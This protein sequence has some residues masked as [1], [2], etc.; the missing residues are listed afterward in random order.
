MKKEKTTI[1]P[2]A[3]GRYYYKSISGN[4]FMNLKSPLNDENYIEITKA[5]FDELTYVAPYE[6]TAEEI[7]AQEVA[8]EIAELK[9]NLFDTDYIV[10][11]IAEDPEHASDLREEYA[12]Q[13]ANRI[14]WRARINELEGE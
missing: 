8:A 9:R 1:G 7:H 13:L 5:E 14:T 6:P 10:I 2:D 11:K 4:G 3:N 12:E